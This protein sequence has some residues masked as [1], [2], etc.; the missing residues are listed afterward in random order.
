MHAT[1]IDP[2]QFSTLD[3][4]TLRALASDHTLVVTL[5]DAQLE[6]GWGEKITAF[7]ANMMPGSGMR[8]LN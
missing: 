5:E 7:Y 8:T 3:E 4:T 1:L 2:L 6:G